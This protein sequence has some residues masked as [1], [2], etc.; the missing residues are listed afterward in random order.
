MIQHGIELDTG[1]K[2]IWL[3]F[4]ML[5]LMHHLLGLHRNSIAES[6]RFRRSN[7]IHG[8]G[9][10]QA[11]FWKFNRV[12][13]HIGRC[14]V[15]IKRWVEFE[16]NHGP[17]GISAHDPEFDIYAAHLD[18]TAD[19]PLH[20]DSLLF[21]LRI[22]ADALARLVPYLY[23]TQEHIPTKSFR[24]Q[25]RWFSQR[26]PDFDPGYASILQQHSA[27]FET[28]AGDKPKGL[29]DVVVHQGGSYQLGW[30]VPEG[31]STFHLTASLLTHSGFREEDLISALRDINYGWCTFLG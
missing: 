4:G 9:Y 6:S 23:N 3:R 22:Q 25:A 5:R 16:A 1:G 12:A 24:D 30:T 7:Y 15:A 27:W 20:L 10:F 2:P 8:V 14:R 21:Y 17:D 11:C 29:R 26:N 28:L 19:L 18:A 31:D 13:D